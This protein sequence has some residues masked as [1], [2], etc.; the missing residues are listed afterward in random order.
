MQRARKEP[1]P[2]KEKLPR[3]VTNGAKIAVLESEEL[4]K[5]TNPLAL[6]RTAAFACILAAIGFGI[7]FI[8]S[9]QLATMELV[10]TTII[11]IFAVAI[12]VGIALIMAILPDYFIFRAMPMNIEI[13]SKVIEFHR[14][15]NV[16]RVRNNENLMLTY[17]REKQ[18]LRIYGEMITLDGTEA[19]AEQEYRTQKVSI[20]VAGEALEAFAKALPST[21]KI[22]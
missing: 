15:K 1:P 5:Q 22:L 21:I 9:M 16:L 20:F 13:Y 4:F 2:K 14:Q 12:C 10:K 6:R 3:R 7:V 8:A 17:E 11:P 19:H 18:K